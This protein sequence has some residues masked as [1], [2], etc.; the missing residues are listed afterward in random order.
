MNFAGRLGG[1]SLCGATSEVSPSAA[2]FLSSYAS[3]GVDTLGR[4][5]GEGPG[6]HGSSRG[7]CRT[8][9]LA[10]DVVKNGNPGQQ[11]R[12]VPYRQTRTITALNQLGTGL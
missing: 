9:T 6:S 10:P 11:G 4:L 5:H 1:S 7:R 2:L 3:G 8:G 12:K